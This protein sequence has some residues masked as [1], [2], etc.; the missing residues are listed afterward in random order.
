MT[1]QLLPSNVVPF[2]AALQRLASSFHCGN[3]HLDS[4]LCSSS[5]LDDSIGKTYVYL[6]ADG[7]T[8]IGYF[9][10]STGSVD[11][12]DGTLRWKAGGAVH[13]NC[14][15]LDVHYQGLHQF[16]TSNGSTTNLSDIF[17]DRCM[18]HIEHIRKNSLGFT[19]VTLNSTEQGFSL[20]KRY[21]F[22]QLDDD[23][24]FSFDSSEVKCIPMY[25]AL[26]IVE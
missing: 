19:F 21:G 26:D 24:T 8:I 6:S 15:A 9:T 25:F 12:I 16:T 5:A 7:Q 3:P 14:F 22:E 2:D 1:E 20:Y 10:L 11:Q 17:L 4:F 18:Q 23:L 13:I